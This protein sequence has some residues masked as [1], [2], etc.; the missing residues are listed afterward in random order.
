MALFGR[1]RVDPEQAGSMGSARC[2]PSGTCTPTADAGFLLLL[3]LLHAQAWEPPSERRH[4]AQNGTVLHCNSQIPGSGDFL[5]KFL[6]KQA[7]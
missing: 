4:G 6:P 2:P 7:A 1:P 5:P 3:A